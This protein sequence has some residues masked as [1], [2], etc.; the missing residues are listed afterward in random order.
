M[1]EH[2]RLAARVIDREHDSRYLYSRELAER[3]AQS[4]FFRDPPPP[5]P[6]EPR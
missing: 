4:V 3:R 6:Q 5:P 2:Q 1:N